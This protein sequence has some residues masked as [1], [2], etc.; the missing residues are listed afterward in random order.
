LGIP[1]VEPGIEPPVELRIYRMF[2]ELG[3]KTAAAKALVQDQDINSM[4]SLRDMSEDRVTTLC[5]VIRRPGGSIEQTL[6]GRANR[7]QQVAAYGAPITM[8]A[9]YNLQLASFYLKYKAMTSR[10]VEPEEVTVN[11]IEALQDYKVILERKM[12]ID[13]DVD[14]I[15][16]LTHER[17]FEW[18]DEF[19]EFL[20]T[21]IGPTS[22]R[23]LGYTLRQEVSVKPEASDPAIGQ[24]NSAYKNYAHEIRERAPIKQLDNK[25]DRHFA[26]DNV[27]VWEILWMKLKKGK[28]HTY[29]KPFLD[30]KD[31]RGAF[32]NLHKQL[33]GKSAIA[34]YATAAQNKLS[35]L[36][37]DG[38]R[39]KH[40]NFDKYLVQHKEQ[41]MILTKLKDFGYAGI[42]ENT[43]MNYF[44][45]GITDP[46]LAMIQSNIQSSPKQTFDEVVEAFRTSIN[47]QKASAKLSGNK[48]SMNVAAVSTSTGNRTNDRAKKTGEK[49][50][51][52]D[53]NK[54][55]SQYSIPTRFYKAPEWNQLS[56]GQR[57]YLRKSSR[58]KAANNNNNRKTLASQVK[59]LK[60]QVAQLTSEAVTESSDTDDTDDPPLKKKKG[61]T[62]LISKKR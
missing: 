61:T 40:W 7:T 55:Y 51:G 49:E 21:R 59:A 58:L 5:K 39:N 50:D 42:D 25:Y 1:A 12:K 9:E 57:N 24:D 33:L 34:N 18:F 11:A 29:L 13:L 19:R 37:L 27:I 6:V 43:K 22:M 38:T 54:D 52:F 46:A 41:H 15:P 45:S 28:C 4:K 36:A 8:I 47:S 56:K 3:I 48:R 30:E 60:A 32:F 62:F 23:P 17:T 14:L 31:G 2:L 26:A 53:I 44:V 35:S 10:T 16:N 20:D